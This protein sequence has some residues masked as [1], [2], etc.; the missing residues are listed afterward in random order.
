MRNIFSTL[1]Y[2]QCYKC[3]FQHRSH[4]ISQILILHTFIFIQ[5]NAFCVSH[6]TFS[7]TYELFTDELLV[8]KGL[9]IFLVYVTV[10]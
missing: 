10:F 5:F 8:S 4:T 9:E 3:I 1:M 2:T 6:E 7:M